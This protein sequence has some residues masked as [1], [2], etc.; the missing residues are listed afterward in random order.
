MKNIMGDSMD[1]G[2]LWSLKADADI[3]SSEA[4]HFLLIFTNFKSDHL[5]RNTNFCSCGK[6]TSH[7]LLFLNPQKLHFAYTVCI[8]LYLKYMALEKMTR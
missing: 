1:K 7:L 3:F 4:S 6:I 8:Y 2:R 5:V